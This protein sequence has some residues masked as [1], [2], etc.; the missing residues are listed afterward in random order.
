MENQ[1]IITGGE[2]SRKINVMDMIGSDI[3]PDILIDSADPDV[4]AV[5]DPK[6]V[7]FEKYGKNFE[8]PEQFDEFYNYA[9]NLTQGYNYANGLK[10][11]APRPGF[12]YG[13]QNATPSRL[14][15]IK[16]KS[17]VSAPI[18]GGKWQV[19][20]RQIA[21][22]KGTYMY[23]DPKTGQDIELPIDPASL[24]NPLNN[25]VVDGMENGDPYMRLLPA[26]TYDPSYQ[27]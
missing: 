9:E 15:T 2:G 1:E 22:D 20:P 23:N 27:R 16:S 5:I 6:E 21:R 11:Q 24:R 26:S 4:D 25:Y 18:T 10:R 19:D 8:T 14:P 17:M 12:W 3:S 7:V 13:A